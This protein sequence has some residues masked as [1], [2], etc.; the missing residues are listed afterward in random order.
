MNL[1][2]HQ[3]VNKLGWVRDLAFDI[4]VD[5]V[6]KVQFE[7]GDFRLDRI[8]VQLI[9]FSP[10]E[11]VATV[12]KF[13]KSLKPITFED[14]PAF[15]VFTKSAIDLIGEIVATL[16]KHHCL[17]SPIVWNNGALLVSIKPYPR[18]TYSTLPHPK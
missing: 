8:E 2:Q 17:S 11:S 14:V 5:G 3:L 1:Q 12:Q 9:P 10:D 16:P 6:G 4:T 15:D 18:F 13:L 7:L